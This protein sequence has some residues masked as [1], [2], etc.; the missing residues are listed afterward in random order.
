MTQQIHSLRA[1]GVMSSHIFRVTGMLVI[2]LRKSA[3]IECNL[4]VAFAFLLMWS[5]E[6]KKVRRDFPAREVK[7]TIPQSS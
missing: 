3:G 7:I 6:N 5:P 1:R 2:A 4:P